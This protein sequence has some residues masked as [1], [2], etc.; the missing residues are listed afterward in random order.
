MNKD[1]CEARMERLCKRMEQKLLQKDEAINGGPKQNEGTVAEITSDHSG[2]F[3]H[4]EVSNE[5]VSVSDIVR[6]SKTTRER[7]TC[8]VE[9]GIQV[10]T[11]FLTFGI[12]NYIRTDSHSNCATGLESM[13]LFD[14]IVKAVDIAIEGKRRQSLSGMGT[15]EKVIL[16]F[17]KLKQN[18]SY[19]FLA[20]LFK[21]YTA[22]HCRTIFLEML[23]I[24]GKVLKVAVPWL[25]KEPILQSMPTCFEQFKDVRVVVDCT[26]IYIQTPKKTC[27]QLI[28]Y[29]QYKNGNTCKVM[30]GVTPS[31]NVSFISKYYGGR[32]TDNQIF[33]QSGLLNLVQSGESI[34]LDKGFRIE[35]ACARR[36][37]KIVRPP[38][39]QEKR[40]FTMEEARLTAA[41]ASA[42]VHVERCNQ[43]I[44]AFKITGDTMSARLIPYVDDIFNIICGVVNLSSPILKDNKFMIDSE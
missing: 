41:I 24:L 14:I 5:S 40:K 12:A 31:G 25:E 18:I 7:E 32:A 6:V 27:C 30:T 8:H 19:A 22:K 35:E 21:S 4:P 3:L 23:V 20:L 16:T 1:L 29:S 9:I 28:T 44:K 15:R 11:G 33:L 34:M 42:R 38:F 26:E 37:V 36:G 10:N 17:M 13:K 43:R 2:E 39:L